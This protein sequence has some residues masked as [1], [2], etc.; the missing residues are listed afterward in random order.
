MVNGEKIYRLI[1][2]PRFPINNIKGTGH[3]I[4][5]NDILEHIER[6]PINM[7]RG[8]KEMVDMIQLAIDEG[9]DVE[10]FNIAD[11]YVNV[12]TERDLKLIEEIIKK[13]NPKILIV[14]PQMKF[15]GGAELL[16]IELA[17][18]L[19][20]KGIKND[21]LTLSSSLEIRNK[22]FN[23]NIIEI[24]NNLDISPPGFKSPRDLFKAINLFRKNLRKIENDYDV[25]NF[26]NFPS[27]WASS[28]KPSLWML[29][30]P[31]NL[32][33]KPNAGRLLKFSNYIRN[34]VDK[35]IVK[36]IDMICVAD[37]FNKKRAF[38]RYGRNSKI[39]YYGVNHEFFSGG[40]KNMAIKKF[41]L[42]DR[43]VIIQSGVLNENKN[44]ID[45]LK[46]IKQIKDKIPEVLII[47][48][49]KGEEEYTKILEKYVE[50]NNLEGNVLFVGNLDRN[51][52]RDLYAACNLGL[53]PVK[54]QGGWLAP[55]EL[56]CSGNPIIVSKN[57]GAASVIDKF[58]LGIV[59]N[60]YSEKIIEIYEDYQT[61]KTKSEIA[62]LFIK[63]NFGWNVFT[64]KL[65]KNFK[66]ISKKN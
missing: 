28:N 9:K 49:G 36:D 39:V 50:I 60:K 55:F 63:K 16:I 15:I 47:L 12:N 25:I 23:T 48:A 35:I 33:S 1:E 17:N 6:T 13:K 65:I 31:P 2:K 40:N 61:Y 32:W 38:E 14:H 18:W 54:K 57:M 34:F 8:E 5:K 66:K 24:K 44:Q 27:T 4:M 64:D 41:N 21:I 45:S 42:K 37:E 51:D 30:E 59:S 53:F 3:C 19:T 11:K 58:N 22:L 52:L 7:N 20:K 62:S 29:N 10:I 43:F 56:L 46:A 26:H